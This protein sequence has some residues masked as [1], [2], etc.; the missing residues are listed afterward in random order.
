MERLLRGHLH[1]SVQR[2]QLFNGF[3]LNQLC[4]LGPGM[5]WR[6]SRHTHEFP[7]VRDLDV[8]L[9]EVIQRLSPG[10]AQLMG[11]T[12]LQIAAQKT[13]G[14]AED[15]GFHVRRKQFNAHHRPDADGQTGQE[16]DKLT[17]TAS[18]FPPCHEE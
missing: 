7:H 6:N 5:L 13:P 12:N 1:L 3:E 8:A 14:I 16:E 2:V 9:P 10:F 18:N 15:E 4:G 17:P 11:H